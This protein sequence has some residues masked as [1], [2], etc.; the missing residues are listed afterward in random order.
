MLCAAVAMLLPLP[1]MQYVGEESYYTLGAYEIFVTQDWW[2]QSIF[3][4]SWPKTPL[5]NWLIIA[6]AQIIGWQH[7]DIAPRIVSVVASWGS[8]FVVFVM[9][10][11]FF[12]SHEHAP[13]LAALI[14]LTMGEIFFWYG[15][16]GYADATFSF[17]IFSSIACMWIAIEDESFAWLAG[18]LVL[19][20]LAFMIKNIS[21]YALLG[22]ASLVLLHR[23]R[24]WQL[25]KKP[26]F[27]LPGLLTLTVPW[28]YQHF[29]LE[30][31][32]NITVAI[33][34]ALRNFTGYG[35]LDYL[36]HWVSYPLLFLAR[37]FPI[38]L[39]VLW[40]YWRE[41]QH[42][43]FDSNLMTLAWILLACLAPFWLSASGTPRYLIPFYGLLALL[44]TGLV[45]QL[46]T[47]QSKLVLRAMALIII[48][49]IPYSFFVLPY[50]KDWRP[51]RDIKAVVED[52]LQTTE[53]KTIRTRDDVATG[54]SI[55]AYLDIRLPAEQYIRWYDGKEKQVYILCDTKIPELGEIVKSYRLRGDD[56][57]LYWQP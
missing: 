50:I 36:G 48:L 25:L 23:H 22:A 31:G 51:E 41:N 46:D 42:Y 32:S 11:R 35:L 1:I 15:W 49:K 16:L 55:G 12:S 37:A 10:R 2:H 6:V 24:R 54:L 27:I 8:A 30:T 47:K 56:V 17:F 44:L 45:L 38:T 57:F 13:W 14:Y 34:D 52:I 21:C 5:Y 26:W 20:S 40:F 33:F 53:G 9:A 18:S 43:T 7:L 29:A 4:I 19:I 3:G 39:L 28:L